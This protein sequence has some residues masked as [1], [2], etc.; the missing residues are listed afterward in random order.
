MEGHARI[1]GGMGA[2]VLRSGAEGK[3]GV[4]PEQKP[5]LSGHGEKGGCMVVESSW[6]SCPNGPGEKGLV[7]TVGA[8]ERQLG[9]KNLA[10]GENSH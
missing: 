4:E 2:A 9:E 3:R 1:W 5:L 10:S 6:P 7:G 8:G